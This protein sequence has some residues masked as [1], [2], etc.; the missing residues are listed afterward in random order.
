[1]MCNMYLVE[2]IHSTDEFIEKC[3]KT[4]KR[5]CADDV[6]RKKGRRIAAYRGYV[7]K[8]YEEL[9]KNY[10]FKGLLEIGTAPQDYM[11]DAEYEAVLVYKN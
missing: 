6:C 11:I 2:G 7:N 3:K 10:V 5:K 8:N 4:C 9:N 1:M